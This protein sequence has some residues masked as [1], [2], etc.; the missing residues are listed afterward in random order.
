MWL[1][2][3]RLLPPPVP[4]SVAVTFGR[5]GIGRPSGAGTP[6]EQ[7]VVDVLADGPFAAPWAVDVAEVERDPDRLV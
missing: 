3:T 5:S 6:A 7:P 4:T 1:L 2:K